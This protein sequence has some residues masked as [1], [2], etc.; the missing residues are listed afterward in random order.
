MA[1]GHERIDQGIVSLAL[2]LGDRVEIGDPLIESAW[3]GDH[4]R[5]DRV[6]QS[7]VQRKPDS[8]APLSL[9]MGPNLLRYGEGFR[10][11]LGLHQPGIV[12]AGPGQRIRSF[13]R[14]V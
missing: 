13:L 14:P 6:A 4:S 1:W 8:I 2:S 7:P 11:E 12:A 3:A 9:R 10:A 5:H